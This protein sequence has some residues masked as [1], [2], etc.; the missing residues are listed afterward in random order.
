MHDEWKIDLVIVACFVT[1]VSSVMGGMAHVA[2]PAQVA[3]IEQLRRD[4]RCL[5]PAT[6]EDVIGQITE[7]NQKIVAAQSYNRNLFGFFVPDD[8]DNVERISIPQ[9]GDCQ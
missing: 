4:S 3:A 1:I 9:V 8:W 7:V 5:N 2:F 6:A